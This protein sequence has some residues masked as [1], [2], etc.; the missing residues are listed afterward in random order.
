MQLNSQWKCICA[1][2]DVQCIGYLRDSYFSHMGTVK[3][4]ND[5]WDAILRCH[6]CNQLW[7]VDS[8]GGHG[9]RTLAIKTNNADAP[10]EYYH[11]IHKQFLIL[12]RGG[13]SNDTCKMLGCINRALK[14]LRYCEHCGFDK[15][16]L[17][18]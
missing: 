1:K 11:D 17:Y 16:H 13:H 3:T 4:L 2:L 6:T 10:I 15:L 12:S 5:G 18:F 7:R 8:G 9:D 14:T